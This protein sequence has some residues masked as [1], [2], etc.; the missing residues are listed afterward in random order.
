[1]AGGSAF[2]PWIAS[3]ARSRSGVGAQSPWQRTEDSSIKVAAWLDDQ[4][5]V[6]SAGSGEVARVSADGGVPVMLPM[7]G[8]VSG[9]S[10][11]SL[12]ALPGSRG[13][14][15]AHCEGNCSVGSAIWVYEFASD[16][17]R[18]LVQNASGVWY[19]PT[20]H[21]LFTDRERG[22]FSAPFDLG[23]LELTGGAVSVIEGVEPTPPCRRRV[24]PY[25][26]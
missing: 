23:R 13:F 18:L 9:I 25:M 16:S 21:L 10:L 12:A 17:A 22:L 7:P 26:S 14:L 2:I 8:A 19:A 5:I 3:C 11:L 24:R 15:T 1:M 20:G 6:Y 4:S